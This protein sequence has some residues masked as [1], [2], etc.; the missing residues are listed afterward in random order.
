MFDAVIA[1]TEKFGKYVYLKGHVLILEP[2]TYLVGYSVAWEWN[3]ED[4][5]DINPIVNI[6]MRTHETI[7]QSITSKETLIGRN[8]L[9]HKF[10]LTVN[11]EFPMALTIHTKTKKIKDFCILPECFIDIIKVS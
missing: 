8:N 4:D 9:Y 2:G 1:F 6:F 7:P 5:E 3:I 11:N 10:I